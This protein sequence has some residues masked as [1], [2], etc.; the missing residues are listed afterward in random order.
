MSYDESD[1]VAGEAFDAIAYKQYLAEQE[2]KLE[3]TLRF[4]KEL[5]IQAEGEAICQKI[6]E[7]RPPLESS[8]LSFCKKYQLTQGE[9]LS[10]EEVYI[11]RELRLIAAKQSNLSARMRFL[12]V[13][14]SKEVRD[15][16]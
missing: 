9:I 4:Q 14:W 15:E 3:A 2:A 6:A 5:E 7:S 10:L 1:L 16:N 11:E 12:V 8:A 13:A